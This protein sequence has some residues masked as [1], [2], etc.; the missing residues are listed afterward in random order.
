M[1]TKN[2]PPAQLWLGPSVE[3]QHQTEKYLQSMFC[4]QHGCTVCKICIMINNH[5]HHSVAWFYPE[6]NYSVEQLTTMLD[7]LSLSLD[8][9]EHYF[10]ILQKADLLTHASANR[11]LKSIEEP[12]QGYHF[13]LLAQRR[14]AML[15][16]IRSRCIIKSFYNNQ[17]EHGSSHPLL[18]FFIH[19]GLSPLDFLKELETCKITEQESIELLDAILA[20]W[21]HYYKRA[22]LE[23]TTRT[24]IEKTIAL[25]SSSLETLPMPGSSKIFWK[26]LFLQLNY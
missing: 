4:P 9:M 3:L 12:P 21:L 14:E 13:I 2:I 23:Q 15:P 25:L 17:E 5:Q 7:L 6:K 19:P 22:C 20:H 8:E 16:T 18:K 24:T 10:I 26:N 11:L 1:N